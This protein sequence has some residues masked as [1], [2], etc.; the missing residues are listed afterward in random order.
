MLG[1]AS[2]CNGC[3]ESERQD[4]LGAIGAEGVEGETNRNRDHE[5]GHCD[6]S[7]CEQ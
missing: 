5:E 7:L 1:S 3:G 6:E 2:R 4:G